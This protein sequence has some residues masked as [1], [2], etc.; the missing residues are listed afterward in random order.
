MTPSSDRKDMEWYGIWG[1]APIP[2]YGMVSPPYHTD[3]SAKCYGILCGISGTLSL[4]KQCVSCMQ[5]AHAR[6]S[7]VCHLVRAQSHTICLGWYTPARGP[8]P[9]DGTGT[10]GMGYIISLR[11]L[12]HRLRD[13]YFRHSPGRSL[14]ISVSGGGR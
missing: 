14:F 6:L 13:H 1:C 3:T 7:L 11:S 9:W 2:G 10:N 4:F 12:G 8:I 5:L